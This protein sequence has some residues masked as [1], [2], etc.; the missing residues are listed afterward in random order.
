MKGSDYGGNWVH[1]VNEDVERPAGW[2][3]L[4]GLDVEEL[5]DGDAEV[6]CEACQQE[7]D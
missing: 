2:L 3:S 4:C 6:T 5:V 1:L 7:T